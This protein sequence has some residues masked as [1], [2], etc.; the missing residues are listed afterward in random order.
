M[1]LDLALFLSQRPKKHIESFVYQILGLTT[2]M[3]PYATNIHPYFYF[4]GTDRQPHH[5]TQWQERPLRNT[6]S[7]RNR[8][9]RLGHRRGLK[10]QPSVMRKNVHY[11]RETL[12]H[13]PLP[14]ES[15]I[16]PSAPRKIRQLLVQSLQ[17]LLAVRWHGVHSSFLRATIHQL[18]LTL[19][20][21][22]FDLLHVALRERNSFT[23]F[24]GALLKPTPKKA[25]VLLDVELRRTVLRDQLRSLH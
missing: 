7:R 17:V 18:S 3:Q 12:L 19:G 22:H 10:A 2:Q 6:Q 9:Q 25:N 16:V 21:G 4:Q 11:M 1:E 5:K 13:G 20:H 8:S 23:M 24:N 14:S 15:R